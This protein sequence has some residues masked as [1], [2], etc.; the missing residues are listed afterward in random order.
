MNELPRD[1]CW[2]CCAADAVLTAH[3]PLL[4]QYMDEVQRG[5]TWTPI[6]GTDYR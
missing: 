2:Q 5:Y 1:N 6:N 3:L 4:Q